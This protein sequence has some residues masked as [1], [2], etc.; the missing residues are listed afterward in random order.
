MS[1]VTGAVAMLSRSASPRFISRAMSRLG[2]V[3]P[4]CPATTR[5]RPPNR[6]ATAP[7]I[8]PPHVSTTSGCASAPAFPNA[9]SIPSASYRT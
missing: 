2:G 1:S 5:P 3:P 9:N 6:S 4:V 7:T 8:N